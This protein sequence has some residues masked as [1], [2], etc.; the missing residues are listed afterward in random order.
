MSKKQSNPPPPNNARPTPPPMPPR[1]GMKLS[2]AN[3][4]KGC[5]S[6]DPEQQQCLS[7]SHT[8]IYIQALD[9][10]GVSTQAMMAM[11]ECGELIA[12]LNAFFNQGKSTPEKVIDE[13]AD[14]EIMCGQLRQIFGEE[15]V[16]ARK[17]F[18]LARLEGILKNRIEHPHS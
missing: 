7:T 17:E 1:I 4:C 2:C 18:K 8:A 13:I 6:G 10:W 9:K 5:E 15:A 3:N 14:V 12:E 11:G 16:N